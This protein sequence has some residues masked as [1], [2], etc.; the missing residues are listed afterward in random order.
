[1]SKNAD[2]LL[3]FVVKSSI[4]PPPLTRVT[5]DLGDQFAQAVWPIRRLVEDGFL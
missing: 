1:M 2:G 5:S 3:T 4:S